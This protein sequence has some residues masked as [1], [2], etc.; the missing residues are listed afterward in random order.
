MIVGVVGEEGMREDEE[1]E[2]LGAQWECEWSC[3]RSS[4]MTWVSECVRVVTGVC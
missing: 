2:N 4:G 3:V 1:W